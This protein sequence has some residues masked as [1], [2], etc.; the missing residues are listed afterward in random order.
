[1]ASGGNRHSLNTRRRL[2]SLAGGGGPR[3]PGAPERWGCP[4]PHGHSLLLITQTGKTVH[5]AKQTLVLDSK[6]KRR[7]Y[8]QRDLIYDINHNYI[9]LT[10]TEEVLATEFLAEEAR[11]DGRVNITVEKHLHKW[12][13]VSARKHFVL[14]SNENATTYSR[15]SKEPKTIKEALKK[16][17]GCRAA[18]GL[19]RRGRAALP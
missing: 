11:H 19:T 2:S 13:N 15:N 10:D 17:G 5:D 9:R 12:N 4:A 7:R 16:D 3:D 14:V 6:G 8:G 1:M 18:T